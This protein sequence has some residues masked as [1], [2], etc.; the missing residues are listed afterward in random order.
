[1]PV[2]ESKPHA[3]T[4][5]SGTEPWGCHNRTR[6]AG[7]FAPARIYADDGSFTLGTQYIEDTLS[8]ECR[9]DASLSD[10]RCA[11]CIHRGSGEAYNEQIRSKGN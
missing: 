3:I 11:G 5:R 4:I 2:I 1:M 7:Y 9:A 8:T 6:S 10:P